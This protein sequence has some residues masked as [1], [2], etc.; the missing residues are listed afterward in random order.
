M[1]GLVWLYDASLPGVDYR[2]FPCPA[3]TAAAAA[4]MTS[5]TSTY[6]IE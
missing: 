3:A 4:A 2:E 6:C 5:S 1:F